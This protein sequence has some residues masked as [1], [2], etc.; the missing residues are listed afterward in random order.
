MT[1]NYEMNRQVT[2]S[3]YS[4]L[5]LIPKDRSKNDS[6]QDKQRFRQELVQDARHMARI[7][8]TTP[9]YDITPE[10]LYL[11][12]GIEPF[13]TPGLAV[14]L[15]DIKRKHVRA[16]LD[17]QRIQRKRGVCDIEKLSFVS[18]QTSSWSRERAYKLGVGYS[19]VE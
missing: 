2:F 10:Q 19:D 13:V 7:L 4:S 6:P 17:E 5:V 11:C 14:R 3:Q 16:V 15:Q 8:E 1:G 12:M 9:A 18:K